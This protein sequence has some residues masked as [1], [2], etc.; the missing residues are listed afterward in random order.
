MEVTPDLLKT[1]V[2]FTNNGTAPAYNLQVHLNALGR[3]E[4]SPVIPQLDPGQSDRARFER[5]VTG[6]RKGRYPMT[7]R[8]D[9]HD[10]NQYPF[11]ALSGMTFHVGED[12]NPSLIAQA[13]DITLNKN[14]ILRFNLKNLGFESQKILATLVLPKEFS[15]P[16]ARKT[17]DINQ[18]AEKALDFEI[19]NFSALPGAI[20]PIFCYFEYD[21]EDTHYTAVTRTLVT[22]AKD[23]NLFRRFRW[24]WISLAAVLAA[25]LIIVIIREHVKRSLKH[26]PD[27]DQ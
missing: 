21:A 27:S 17:V 8:V 18:R 5:N 2:I 19:G 4:N 11:S 13:K 6:V 9:F 20:Y 10:A 22:V 25:I 1:S 24:L 16:Q 23:E 7:V 14:R 15:T 12:V 26:D 3:Q